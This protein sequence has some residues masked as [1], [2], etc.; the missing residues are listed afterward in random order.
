ME[1]GERARA[2]GGY[3]R[4]WYQSYVDY[5]NGATY[6]D[7]LRAH[8]KNI[9]D[10]G[11]EIEVKGITPHDSY[12]HSIVEMRCAREVI[13]NAV[14]AE[15]EGYDAFI[16]G[17]FQDA[18]LYEARSV[19]NIPVIAL[20]EASMLYS[21]QLGQRIGIVTINTRYIPWFHHQIAKY[22]LERRVTG[23]HAMQFEPGQILKAYE[24]QALADEVEVLF[25]NQA[26]PLV[27]GGCEVL[28][29]GGGIPMLLFSALHG[30]AVDGA[31]VING[32]PI[33]VKMAEMAVKLRRLTGLNVS[34]AAEFIQPPP[35]I[36]EE[37]MTHPRGL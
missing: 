15:R 11:T 34:R 21:C 24:S 29:P 23:I 14:R 4:I 10:D 33:A 22:G 6:W 13:C 37:F 17:H 3:M 12:A 5:E 18:G 32:I 7:R 8:L 2:P 27:A 35:H 28:I 9:V 36:I 25:A 16:I 19:V 30:H 1:F 20:G 31:T 26:K